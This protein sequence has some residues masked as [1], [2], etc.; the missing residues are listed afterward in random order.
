MKGVR[1]PEAI[2]CKWKPRDFDWTNLRAFHLAYPTGRAW[3][4]AQDVTHAYTQ[5]N[6]G[7]SAKFVGLPELIAALTEPSGRP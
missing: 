1:V 5:R 7:L 3:V 6:D 4:V 2:E